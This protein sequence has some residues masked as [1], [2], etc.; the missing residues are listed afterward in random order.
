MK[1]AENAMMAKGS[2][3]K[4]KKKK[5]PMYPSGNTTNPDIEGWNC[6][7][8]GHIRSKCPKKPRKKQTSNKGKEQEAHTSQTQ[9]DYVFSFNVVGE[10]FVG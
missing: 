8:K 3:G 5:N 1:A 7:E 10:A 9:D 2:K 6:T 4:G